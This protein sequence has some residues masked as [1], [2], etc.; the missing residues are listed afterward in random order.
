MPDNPSKIRWDAENVI[1]V[2]LKIN[3]N[4]GP[5]LF[6][7]LAKAENKTV[8]LNNSSPFISEYQKTGYPSGYYL[9]RRH[10]KGLVADLPEANRKEAIP[11]SRNCPT[12]HWQ[13]G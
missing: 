11:S 8:E 2:G 10:R 1:K 7:L 12:C 13:V 4:Q 9:C 5:E 3:R 6:T